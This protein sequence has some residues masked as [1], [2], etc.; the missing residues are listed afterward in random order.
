MQMVS[1]NGVR[2]HAALT[3]PVDGRPIVFANSLGTDFRVWDR[4]LARL[5]GDLRVLRYDK[6]GHGLSEVPPGPYTIDALTADA[7]GLM[8]WAGM[9]GALFVGLSIGGLIG[10]ALAS[11]RPELCRALVLMDTAAKIGGAAL[12]QERIAAIRAGSLSAIAPATMERWF[13]TSFRDE[14]AEEVAGWRTMLERMPEEGYIACAEAIAAADL[15]EASRA[16]TLP[17]LAIC[18]EEDGSTPPDLV[19]ATADL[20]AGCRFELIAGAGHL[21]CVEAPERITGLLT[22]FLEETRDG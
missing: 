5:P 11:T 17:T 13:S 21:P 6:R 8:D 9:R 4:V 19:R 7:A 20:I 10:Q 2:L 3:G 18:G 22:A 14:Q 1:V 12:W 15:T 16:L